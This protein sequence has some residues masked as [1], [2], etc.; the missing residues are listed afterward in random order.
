MQS[1]RESD[2]GTVEKAAAAEQ[3]REDLEER[4][5]VLEKAHAGLEAEVAKAQQLERDTF[6]EKEEL[7]EKLREVVDS[8][9]QMKRKVGHSCTRQTNERTHART[10]ARDKRATKERTHAHHAHHACTTHAAGTQAN[11]YH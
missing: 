8:A 5:E 11:T 2:R 1:E 9:A 3:T 10:H 7:D 6:N 4:N